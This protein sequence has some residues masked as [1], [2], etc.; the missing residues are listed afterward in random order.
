[1][2]AGSQELLHLDKLVFDC[3]PGHRNELCVVVV[4]L[5]FESEE[6]NPL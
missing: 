6:N 3:D 4:A 2:R 1:M 5:Q